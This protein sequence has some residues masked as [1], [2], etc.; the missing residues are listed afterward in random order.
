MA[1]ACRP[2]GRVSTRAF[3]ALQVDFQGIPF[4]P[5][6]NGT[7][8]AVVGFDGEMVEFTEG[9]CS[10]NAIIAQFDVVYTIDGEFHNG[11]GSGT[12]D[13]DLGGLFMLSFEWTG[14]FTAD[15]FLGAFEGT[16][17]LP[18]VGD[19]AA[20]GRF[21]APFVSPWLDAPP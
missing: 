9:T 7:L 21:D 19:V 20:T 14:A 11:V 8:D 12:I 18:F 3:L 16:V 5:T 2:G 1:C 6:C 17:P 15:G 4:A 13:Y 10:L